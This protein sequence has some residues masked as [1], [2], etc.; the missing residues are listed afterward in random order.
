MAQTKFARIRG[1]ILA[2]IH[3]TNLSFS[4]QKI[5]NT[6]VHH[7]SILHTVAEYH[8]RGVENPTPQKPLIV[9]AFKDCSRRKPLKR[10]TMTLR[11]G[12]ANL[13]CAVPIQKWGASSGYSTSRLI[14]YQVARF[15]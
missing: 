8:L 2:D 3:T 4:K 1:L 13:E 9:K 5:P 14:R 12:S 6:E 11:L 10:P 7:A 15:S